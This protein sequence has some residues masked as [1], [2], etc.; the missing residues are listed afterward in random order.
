MIK[1]TVFLTILL[2]LGGLALA[3][4]GGGGT[5]DAPSPPGAPEVEQ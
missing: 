3:C 1:R 5:S 4:G 2:A